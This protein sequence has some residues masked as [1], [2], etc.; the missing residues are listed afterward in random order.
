[1]RTPVAV[2]SLVL[3]CSLSAQQV[4]VNGAPSNLV[5]DLSSTATFVDPLAGDAFYA[6]LPLSE[7]G[8]FCTMIAP[9]SMD[10]SWGAGNWVRCSLTATDWAYLTTDACAHLPAP[11][12]AAPL[13]LLTSD[14]D[15]GGYPGWPGAPLGL[16]PDATAFA[17]SWATTIS[18]I[19]WSWSDEHWQLR[20]RGWN[21]TEHWN[22]C[23][24][25]SLTPSFDGFLVVRITF[26]FS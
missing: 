12:E 18:G 11:G 1:M 24:S 2:A 9:V 21:P 3:T 7:V 17:G 22:A 26:A 6:F 14:Y 25:S 5:L 13:S 16:L 10:M 4:Y 19:D 20:T 15:Y 8:S 23:G